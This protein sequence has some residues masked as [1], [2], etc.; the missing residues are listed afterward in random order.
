MLDEGIAPALLNSLE[1]RSIG[2][3]RGGRVVAVA[4]DMQRSQVFYFGSTGGGVWKTSD[5][6]IYWENISDGFFKR[7]SVGALA[8]APSDPN[9]LYAG[10]GETTIRG[11]V[12]HG[13]G[14][15]RS[16]D[17]GKTWT[18][19]GLEDTRHIGK[20]RI[21]PQNPDLVYV[22]ALGH[23]H[24]PNNAR[25]I[26]RSRDGG[27]NWEH[28]LF[29]GEDV[30]AHD[31]A[32]DPHNPRILYAACWRA[33]RL[34]YTLQSGGEG[35]GLFK[36]ND[37]GDSWT[38]ITRRPGLPTGAV[39]K[40]GVAVSGARAERVWAIVE[41]EDGALFRS[42]DGGE[43]W[44]R[45]SSD[46]DLRKRPWYYQHVFA[47]P[48]DP[49]T[50]WVLNEDCFKSNDGGRTFF[51]VA[52]PHGDH[53][54][55]W[56]DPRDPQRIIM[57]DDG[58]ACVAFNG[59]QAWSSLY[60]QP[61]AEFYHVTTDNQAPYRV[62]GAQ[63]DNTTITVPSRSRLSAITRAEYYEIG[64][65]ESSHIA[66]RPDNPDIVY[67]GSYLGYLTRYDHRTG[68]V[69]DISVWPEA[70]LGSP[71]RDAKYRFQWTFP[72]LLSPHDPGVLYVTGNHVFRS[73]DEGNSWEELSP[74]LTRND[75]SKMADSGGPI[76]HDNVGTEYYGTIFAFAESP[77]ERGF[78]WAGSDD[79]L[80][81]ISRD[82]GKSWQD[83]TPTNLPRW[84]LI[85]IIEPSPYDPAAAYLAA[86]C[87]KSDDFQPYLFKTR[88]YG[89]TWEKITSGIRAN[90]FTRVIRADPERRGLLYTGTETG[91]YVSFDDGE[92]W[93]ALQLNLPTVPIHDLVIKDGD[94]VAATHGRSFWIL[95]DISP[96]RQLGAEV[97]ES[98]AHL[99]PP[100]PTTRFVAL[101][102]FGRS[103]TP[104][105]NYRF[106]GP[107]ILPYRQQ[108]KAG[109]EKVDR[110]LDAGQNPPRGVVVHYYL[111][112]KPE[113]EVT[114]SFL[115]ASG[116]IIRT[117][118]SELK[119][120]ERSAAVEQGDNTHRKREKKDEQEQP[121][122]LKEA[123]ANRFV[124]NMR[125]PDPVKIE[126]VD[127]PA[128][129][130]EGPLAPVGTY[131]VQLKIGDQ[132]YTQAFQIQRDPNIAAT[133]E[134]LQN[135]FELLLA[136][137]D[138]ISETHRA[139]NA[140]RALRRQVDEWERR[141]MGYPIH[142]TMMTE[143]ERIKQRLLAIEQDLLQVKA[144]TQTDTMD[145]PI[146]L[147]GK[148]A[149]LSGVVASA[150]AAPTRQAQEVFKE[151]AAR[152][153]SLLLQLREIVATD[154]AAFNSMIQES[155][156]PA[157]MPPAQDAAEQA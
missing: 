120:D 157:I 126:G 65:G 147:S 78:L 93:Q 6:G 96:L 156:V 89:K 86:T 90:D 83:V 34:P 70:Y 20:L 59:G 17:G 91:V 94:L 146:K 136:I 8:V 133:Q 111:R 44:E 97:G 129:G 79:G 106:S 149:E 131:Q 3:Y 62:Y 143:G 14:V 55:L 40:I 56:I 35:C 118:S 29:R 139:V 68:Q 5:G 119:K 87:Y 99:F 153:T 88:D 134:D 22:A 54:D 123:G 109:G 48:Q 52:M 27:K 102:G 69:R 42:D 66:V 53:H 45:Q 85:S 19:M 58:G 10:M 80:V 51:K 84:A 140:I 25:G 82:G 130:L 64:G 110:Y 46:P 18:H 13:D 154:V 39:G 128:N 71:A 12:S 76:T 36:S 26:Y 142:E 9:V 50:V 125:Y 7:A 114:L 81:H 92:H 104:G 98:A 74:D 4:A 113:G 43:T 33:R 72:I 61:T 77:L 16:S 148:L 138:R 107:F 103:V 108:E 132:A 121:R 117:F 115:E 101:S 105:T 150:D 151:L 141:T 124:W 73:T 31:L 135:Q 41:A 49:E 30:G 144:R 38:E 112:E 116:K 60:N 122:V 23:A 63:Q 137:R 67:A 155:S 1:W 100:R 152:L 2:P 145:F 37:G 75:T 11:N 127:D 95:D 15:Y 21:H 47:D 57:G 24:G 32:M 28:I